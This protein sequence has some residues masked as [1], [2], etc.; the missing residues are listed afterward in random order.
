MHVLDAVGFLVD[1]DVDVINMSWSWW[2]GTGAASESGETAWTNLMADYLAYDRNIVCVAAVNQLDAYVRPTAP[3]SSRN[4]ITVGGLDDSLERAWGQQDYGPTLDG[5]CKPD[6]LG[7]DSANAVTS[8]PHWRNGIPAAEGW[9]G[10]SFATP[11]VTGAVAQML[12]YARHHGQ[13]EDHRVIKAVIM[14][15]A[16]KALDDDGSSWSHSE[17]VPLDNQQ[18]TGVLDLERVHAM[19]SA[20]QQAAGTVV[21][22]GYD[23][24]MIVGTAAEPPSGGEVVYVLGCPVAF[25]AEL[26]ATLVW[27]R[28]ALWY[29]ANDN[30]VIDSS[31]TFY[32]DYWDAQDNL[33]LTLYRDGVPVASSCSTIDNVEHIYVPDAPQ[34]LYQLVV[35]R[36]A[37]PNSG[38]D[39]DFALAWD[40]TVS[41]AFPDVD[42]DM[43]V[44]LA[45][46]ARFQ[47]CCHTSTAECLEDFD[48]NRSGNVD[49]GE[50]AVIYATMIGV[51]P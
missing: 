49:L 26:E 18:G 28:H 4:V 42:H 48:F 22:P 14:N 24:A 15:S 2:S 9:C 6:L 51:A 47:R 33:D 8:N 16:A 36:L 45:D 5:R 11:F 19:Y 44:D 29:D 1:H 43:D 46:F 39:E 41:W 50:F 10:T 40:S 37:V 34:G 31:D 23:F 38:A 27:D 7:N 25:Q 35:Q 12:D 17:T 21:V 13:N 3:G 20:G 32:H 30:D